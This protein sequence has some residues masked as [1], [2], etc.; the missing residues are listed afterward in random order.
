[1]CSGL[2]Y[3]YS[4]LENNYK[5]SLDEIAKWNSN[6]AYYFLSSFKK[7]SDELFISS[8]RYAIISVRC[9]LNDICEED[10][11]LSYC[12]LSCFYHEET[13][14]LF[15]FF[16]GYDWL[17]EDIDDLLSGICIVGG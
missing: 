7:F 15:E 5:T 3:V 12:E 8:V 4:V 6:W 11:V 9:C 14:L 16:D 2:K 1:M 13:F 17:V 10:I